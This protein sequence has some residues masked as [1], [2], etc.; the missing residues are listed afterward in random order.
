M[1][2]GV[3]AAMQEELAAFD[4]HQATCAKL[5]IV[6]KLAG[7]CKVNAALAA[8]DLIWNHSVDQIIMI[9]T[10]GALDPQLD[11]GDIVIAH[12]A[13]QHDVDV[14]ALGFT[15]GQI[16][17]EPDELFWHW[18]SNG[19]LFDAAWQATRT[20]GLRHKTGKILTGDR[21]VSDPEHAALLRS[22]LHGT[23]I[24][25]EGA[26]VAQVCTKLEVPWLILRVI[27]DRADH[28]SPVD[29]AQFLPRA[30]GTLAKLVIEIAQDL[31]LPD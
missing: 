26:A 19:R 29:F 13:L 24:E 15:W 30:S 3:I 21:F 28:S 11:I 5:G 17:F 31:N 18:H 7:V 9:G 2:L 8:A 20:L 6:L 23:C 12:N 22:E 16:P 25:M 14:R 27:S 1:K 4:D 10:A